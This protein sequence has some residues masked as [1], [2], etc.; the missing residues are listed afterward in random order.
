MAKIPILKTASAILNPLAAQAGQ[1]VVWNTLFI[2]ARLVAELASMLLLLNGLSLAA[3]GVL[4]IIRA[5]V[6]LLGTWVDL[7]IER[8]LPKFIPEIQ[9]SNGRAGVRW[10]LSRVMIVKLAVLVVVAIGLWLQ[11]GWFIGYLADQVNNVGKLGADERALLLDQLNNNGWFFIGAVVL[12]LILGAVYDVLMSYL[13]S[14]FKQRAWNSIGLANNLLQPI[15]ISVAVLLGW[16]ITGVVAA[17]VITAL[18]GVML[19]A[20]QVARVARTTTDEPTT[21]VPRAVL[22]RF[23]PYSSLSYLFNLSDI[24]ASSVFAIFFLQGLE[25]AALLTVAANLV[26]QILTYLYMPMVGLQVPLFTRARS[27]EGGG[28]LPGAYAAVCRILLLLLIPGSIGL[29][30][31]AGPLILAQAP[32]YT[33]AVSAI[34][35]LT[36]LLFVESLLATSQNALMVSERYAPIIVSRVVA[37]ASVPLAALLVPL[38]GVLGAAIAIGGSRV[39]AGLVVFVAGRRMLELRFPWRFGLRLLGA[40]AIMGGAL[41]PIVG[42][43]P[44]IDASVA[45]RLIL[46]GLILLVAAIGAAIFVAA[47]RLFG[48]LDARD[49]QQLANTRLPLKRLLLKML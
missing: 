43:L 37:F 38:Y 3:F 22:R 11:R 5:G 40:A 41:F 17:M 48:G 25:Q 28:T 29:M 19:A 33:D 1:A 7:G 20:W 4:A 14:Y 18:F 9:H 10:L 26:R 13:I 46:A 32:Q 30:V 23:V 16:D 45:D 15:L 12:L 44:P 31:L 27:G 39:M 34:V 6:S 42:L 8:A 36:P 21:V 24:A 47:F 49:R 2:P 35:L